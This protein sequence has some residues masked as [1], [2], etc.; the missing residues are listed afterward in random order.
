[1]AWYGDFI[2]PWVSKDN[3]VS[4]IETKDDHSIDDDDDYEY[5]GSNLGELH[6]VEPNVEDL[7][8]NP[9]KKTKLEQRKSK[10]NVK[11]SKDLEE[12]EIITEL[13]EEIKA[14]QRKK[15]QFKFDSENL[16]CSTLQ[17]CLSMCDLSM[18]SRH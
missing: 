3:L 5:N 8:V 4:S 10:K 18:D 13:Y 14:K 12:T 6:A 16:F 15:E 9:F 2:C 17:V 7:N 1:M 11:N